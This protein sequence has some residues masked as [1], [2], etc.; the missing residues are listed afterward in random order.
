[1]RIFLH[2]HFQS[3]YLVEDGK[4]NKLGPLLV[5][6]GQLLAPNHFTLALEG[7]HVVTERTTSKKA[8]SNPKEVDKSPKKVSLE[9]LDPELADSM[10][11]KAKKLEKYKVISQH[12]HFHVDKLLG[13]DVEK[14]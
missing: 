8:S 3:V 7:S 4:G 6:A 5:K 1:M 13:D 14:R 12:A 11:K 2:P 9:L 10:S